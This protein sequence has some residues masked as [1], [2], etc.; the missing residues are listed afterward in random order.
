MEPEN[1]ETMLN[2]QEHQD[3][4]SEDPVADPLKGYSISHSIQALEPALQ[5]PTMP[6]TSMLTT[7]AIHWMPDSYKHGDKEVQDWNPD[8]GPFK[9]TL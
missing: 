5:T 8:V 7:S 1:P 3:T 4:E 6:Q 2:L 9:N